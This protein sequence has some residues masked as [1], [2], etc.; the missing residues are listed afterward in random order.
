MFKAICPGCSAELIGVFPESCPNCGFSVA[1]LAGNPRSLF[2]TRK[3]DKHTDIIQGRDIALYGGTY[4]A[5]F[6]HNGTVVLSDLV[7]FAITFGD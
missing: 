5:S 1:P 6:D 4:N 7:R 3:W 2:Q